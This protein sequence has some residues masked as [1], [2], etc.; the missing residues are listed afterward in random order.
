M[1]SKKCS[2]FSPKVTALFKS[3]DAC[4]I[5]SEVE[6]L[7]IDWENFVFKASALQEL[8]TTF[9]DCDESEEFYAKVLCDHSDIFSECQHLVNKHKLEMLTTVDFRWLSDPGVFGDA[10]QA[11]DPV[12]ALLLIT[13]VLE[14]S[15]GNFLWSTNSQV[16]VPSL[17]K[18]L[19]RLPELKDHFGSELM[20]MSRI[21]LGTPK[22]LNL[23]NLVWHGFVLP[24]LDCEVSWT[25]A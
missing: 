20:A 12:T 2:Y 3:L 17:L 7:Y 15:I 6:P 25:H 14:R 4:E 9:S 13:P 10:L 21:L 18:D 24:S 23:R 11:S 16:T 1:N 22:S 19:L 5:K 8:M